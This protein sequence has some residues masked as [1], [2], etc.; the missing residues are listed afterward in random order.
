M[1]HKEM[2]RLYGDRCSFSGGLGVQSV[3]PHGTPEEVT[4]HVRATIENLGAGGG[5]IIGP[6]HII[7]RDIP[8]ANFIAM[9]EAI[10]RFGRY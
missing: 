6:A 10:D 7:E 3:L 1:D 4:E 8:Y 9:V 2:K 5:L